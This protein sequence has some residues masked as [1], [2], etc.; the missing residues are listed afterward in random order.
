MIDPSRS[1]NAALALQWVIIRARLM[2]QQG[3]DRSSLEH[4][5]D[6]AEYLAG[7]IGDSEDRTADFRRQ[8]EGLA[9][10]HELMQTALDRFENGMSD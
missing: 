4:V 8:L 9:G 10:A 3:S 6:V 5:L 1:S 7:L 2:V